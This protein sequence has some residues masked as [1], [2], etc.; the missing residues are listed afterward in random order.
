MNYREKQL[1]AA[2]VLP[3]APV[4]ELNKQDQTRL[5][6]S[7]SKAIGA[8]LREHPIVRGASGLDHPAQAISVDDKN[9]RVIIISAEQNARIAALIQ[10]DVQATMPDVRVL[11]ARPLVVDLGDIARRIFRTVE[12][13]RININEFKTK[14]ERIQ[15]LD[16]TRRQR[17]FRQ[18][19]KAIAPAALAFK[20]VALPTIA[21][22]VYVIEQAAYLDWH[23]ISQSLKTDSENPAI[24]FEKLLEI[25]NT[26]IDRRHGVCPIPLYEFS[27]SDWSL[28]FEGNHIEDI[29]NRLR[30]LNIYQYFFPAPDHLALGLADN[31]MKA[32]RDI[33]RAVDEA[34]ELGHPLGDSE[35]VRSITA[36]P[37][38]LEALKDIGYIAEG[39]HG[40]EV[41]PEGQTSRMMIKYRPREGLIAK[42]INRFSVNANLSVTAKDF[43]GH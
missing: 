26:A 14:W 27:E 8:E 4:V 6:G 19:E 11:V 23:Q 38:I 41:S 9:R 3:D 31:G 20:H 36:V 37:E 24:S 25:D 16:Q 29:Q 43:L 39:E 5:W 12:G 18:F 7:F 33:I 17:Y 32:G 22:I 13:A 40:I 42:L 35:I 15:K 30:E 28:F 1:F 21:Q 2:P 34:A 10:G